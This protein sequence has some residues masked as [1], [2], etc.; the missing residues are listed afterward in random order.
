MPDFDWFPVGLSWR[1]AM[2]L[3]VAGREFSGAEAAAIGLVNQAFPAARLV[4]HD[5]ISRWAGLRPL[6][7]LA[8]G[9]PSDVSR[10]H[11]IHAPAPGWWDITGGKL[12]TY[13][14][15][16]EQAVDRV[17]ALEQGV[18]IADGPLDAVVR[19]E[20][21]LATYLGAATAA[22]QPSAPPVLIR[23]VA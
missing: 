18:L 8:G 1:H 10:A 2:E 5:I 23:G 4:E 14:L 21:V 12:T 13:R 19:N 16:A 17:I 6:V 7:A 20:R 9:S 15:M 22:T 3:Q 11:E